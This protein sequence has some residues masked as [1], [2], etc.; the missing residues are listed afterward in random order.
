MLAATA[1]TPA[2]H[3]HSLLQFLMTEAERL[4]Y[5]CFGSTENSCKSTLC[6]FFEPLIFGRSEALEDSANY[7]QSCGSTQ[8]GLRLTLLF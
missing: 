7:R 6:L 3:L 5:R 2:S 8:L 1:P 4:F